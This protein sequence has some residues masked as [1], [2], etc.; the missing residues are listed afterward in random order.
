MYVDD[1]GRT[2]RVTTDRI[3]N[4]AN[5]W[6]M[7]RRAASEIVGDLLVSVPDAVERA[8]SETPGVPNQIQRIVAS[9]L[10]RLQKSS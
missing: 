7:A 2:D 8:V 10:D 6:G 1:V 9:Q 4:E 5:S 3:L